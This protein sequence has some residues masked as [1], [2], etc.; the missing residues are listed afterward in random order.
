MRRVAIIGGTGID[1]L[2]DFSS[3]L[4]EIRNEYGSVFYKERDGIIFLPRHSKSHA[5]PPHLI[6]YKANIEALRQ[7]GV[8][9]A[10]T[11]YAVGSITEKL[12]P[13][14]WGIVDDFIDISGHSETFFIGLDKGVKHVDMTEPFDI[15]L[16]KR[17]ESI[18][19]VKSHVVYITTVGPRLETK[20]EIRAY[21]NMGA[22][23]VG[24]TLSS[25]A[26]LLKEAGIKN[27]SISYSINWAA[28]VSDSIK[29][30]SDNEI[31]KLTDE[32][33]AVAIKALN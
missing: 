18:S 6:N 31:K 2:D 26:I 33:V 30:V 4:Q 13:M 15:E 9:K 27:A 23:V 25:E 11:I 10:I 24:M 3:C 12:K 29:F 16:K 1:E 7:L 22:D 17:I 21:R 32:I 19:G 5:Y 20:A 14:E 28:G 8:C